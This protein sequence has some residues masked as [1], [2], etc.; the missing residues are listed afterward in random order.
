MLVPVTCTNIPP[1]RD[2]IQFV[3]ALQLPLKRAAVGA[4][5]SPPA[6]EHRD[7]FS[8]RRL[9]L[10]PA[11]PDLVA[12]AGLRTSD[13]SRG[14]SAAAATP[15]LAMREDWRC[16]GGAIGVGAAE[17]PQRQ[18]AGHQPTA[19]EHDHWGSSLEKLRLQFARR[20]DAAHAGGSPAGAPP[21]PLGLPLPCAA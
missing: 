5:G 16:R 21:L 10:A 9:L 7:A 2:T 14:S 11:A 19:L 3:S 13:S 18:R 12:A 1:E 20:L 6:L 8:R 17:Q 15:R 4:A